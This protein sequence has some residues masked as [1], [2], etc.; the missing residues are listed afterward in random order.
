M[1]EMGE[2]SGIYA[3]SNKCRFTGST[4][5][6]PNAGQ[7]RASRR[8]IADLVCRNSADR[9]DIFRMGNPVPSGSAGTGHGNT[10]WQLNIRTADDNA[11]K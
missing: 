4:S 11:C 6:K 2:N 1:G 7:R 9:L 10:T 3:N 5:I 8:G